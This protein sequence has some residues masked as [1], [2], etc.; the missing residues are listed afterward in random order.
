[1]NCWEGDSRT[2][3]GEA[4][5]PK[6]HELHGEL[7]QGLWE[8]ECQAN[9]PSS[10]KVCGLAGE[11]RAVAAMCTVARAGPSEAFPWLGRDHWSRH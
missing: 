11:P 3:W 2:G 5:R 7:R 1:M 4:R 8:T 9:R 6:P 10:L